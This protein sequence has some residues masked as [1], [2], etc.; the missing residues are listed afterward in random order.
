[1]LCIDLVVMFGKS[2]TRVDVS[3]NKVEPAKFG[4]LRKV[5]VVMKTCLVF[6]LFFVAFA[7][8]TSATDIGHAGW[9]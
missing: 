4:T 8:V 3:I 6:A 5:S 2:Y 1:M 9:F 7:V